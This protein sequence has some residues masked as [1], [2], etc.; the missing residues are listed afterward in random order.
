MKEKKY[1]LFSKLCCDLDFRDEVFTRG[2][3]QHL[4]DIMMLREFPV[5]QLLGCPTFNLEECLLPFKYTYAKVAKRDK[6]ELAVDVNA[7]KTFLTNI[8][9]GTREHN[10]LYL[11]TG[12]VDLEKARFLSFL[13]AFWYLRRSMH[14]T[15]TQTKSKPFYHIVRGG[16]DDSLRDSK[17]ERDLIGDTSLLVLDSLTLQSSKLKIEKVIDLLN[18]YTSTHKPMDI[19]VIAAGLDPLALAATYLNTTFQAGFYLNEGLITSI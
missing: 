10:S 7:Q 17:N 12:I 15:T 1:Q 19:I 14:D 16:F 18:I 6:R 13:L 5:K 8:L 4:L 9:D 3:S 2:A 11:I